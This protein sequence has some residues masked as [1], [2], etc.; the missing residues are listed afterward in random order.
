MTWPVVVF[1][2]LCVAAIFL[3]VNNWSPF[4]DL[5]DEHDDLFK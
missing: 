3:V 5:R 1:C 2:V 4:S